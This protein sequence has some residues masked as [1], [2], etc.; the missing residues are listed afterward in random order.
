MVDF[1]ST[2]FFNSPLKCT[3]E[4]D[5]YNDDLVTSEKEERYHAAYR[6]MEEEFD[7]KY[8]GWIKKELLAVSDWKI[9]YWK[10]KKKFVVKQS[11]FERTWL[12]KVRDGLLNYSALFDADTKKKYEGSFSI[13]YPNYLEGENLP[14]GLQTPSSFFSPEFF[15]YYVLHD[16]KG[17]RLLFDH[18]RSYRWMD[19]GH[20]YWDTNRL[21]Q[22]IYSLV[23]DRFKEQ[24]AEYVLTYYYLQDY[25]SMEARTQIGRDLA[26]FYR[27]VAFRAAAEAS[28]VY[29]ESAYWLNNREKCE[30]ANFVADRVHNFIMT[31]FIDPEK[32]KRIR[33][34]HKEKLDKICHSNLASNRYILKEPE[35]LVAID[36]D[37]VSE[38]DE[39]NREI[40]KSIEENSEKCIND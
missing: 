36:P 20:F 22:E 23:Y 38:V 21:E 14:M 13:D 16:G 29:A 12:P 40:R 19:G 10:D 18:I 2:H 3:I 27:E 11:E 25:M 7:R 39:Q 33:H 1:D 26:D 30:V 34:T 8:A 28:Y 5:V 6:T 4:H 32:F 15:D 37:C 35:C 24:Y 31:A 9:N 17:G